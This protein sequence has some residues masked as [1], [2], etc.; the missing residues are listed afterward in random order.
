MSDEAQDLSDELVVC[1]RQVL[2]THAAKA[3]TGVCAVCGVPRCP[4]WINAYDTLAAAHQV[5]SD[6]PPPWEPFRPGGKR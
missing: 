4:D 2:V 1:Y 3:D 5:M 6:I